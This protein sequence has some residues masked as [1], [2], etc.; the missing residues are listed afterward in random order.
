MADD[1]TT[2]SNDTATDPTTGAEGSAADELLSAGPRR[3]RRP[4]RSWSTDG[5]TER[6]DRP[7]SDSAW[8]WQTPASDPPATPPVTGS[9]PPPPVPP[10][11]PALPPRPNAPA[12]NA[13][14]LAPTA[15][16]TAA[17]AEPSLGVLLSE[18]RDEFGQLRDALTTARSE[19]PSADGAIVSGTELA[20]VIEGLGISLGNG[21]ATLLSDHR[22]LLAR[23]IEAGSDRVLEEVG[24]RLRTTTNQVI[25]GVEAKIRHVNAQALAGLADQIDARLDQVE[26]DLAGLRAVM[27]ELPDQSEVS[28]RLDAILDGVTELTAEQAR[29]A[30]STRVAPALLAALDELVT[31]ALDRVETS[32]SQSATRLIEAS[33]RNPSVGELDGE[34]IVPDEEG[35]GK[36]TREI[37][38]LRRRIGLRSEARSLE[39]SDKQLDAI[40]EKVAAKLKGATPTAAPATRARKTPIAATPAKATAKAAPTKAKAAKK[41]G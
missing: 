40:A 9:T 5:Q 8:G 3:R 25:D 23:D 39:L 21:M 35:L 29:D 28:T 32:L 1:D 36:L 2:A 4:P 13:P 19:Q 7:M 12:P 24:R 15:A 41:R 37:V 20:A 26:K 38:A 34:Q 30:V 33:E 10:P 18:L 14:I 11:Q 17:A 16:A 27:L 31:P 22:A 6:F